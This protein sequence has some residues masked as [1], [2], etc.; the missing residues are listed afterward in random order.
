MH[1]F[2]HKKFKNN[3][4]EYIGTKDKLLVAI[5]SGQDSLCL[6]QLI[7]DCINKQSYN[8]QAIYIDHQWKKDSFHHTQHIVNIVKAK[9]IPIS[10]YE[11]KS[12]AI[13]ENIA[14]RIRYKTFIKHAIQEKC[15]VVMTGHHDNDQIETFLYNIIRGTS[16][17][18]ISNL[19]LFKKLNKKVAILRPLINFSKYE[20][21]WF[22]RLFHL[23]IWSD[24]TNYNFSMRRN[25][26]RHELIPYLQ[27][28]F[29]PQIKQSIAKFINL[30]AQENEYIKENTIKLYILITHKRIISLN[31]SKLKKQ[32]RVL[33]KRVIKLF[34]YYHFNKQIN[35][36]L[37][38]KILI[39]YKLQKTKTI[40][41]NGLNIFYLNGKIY[42]ISR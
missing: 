31:L 29:N 40:F 36:Y 38:N 11:I 24:M 1:T 18:G 17:S 28:Y 39:L 2:S 30:C 5:S 15:P 13:S 20:I 8:I 35:N 33:K 19:T 7:N 9:N 25:R 4:E 23:P 41:F 26:I 6:M 12:L 16:I 3:C 21:S 22:C 32:H 34:F 10:I 37:I 42:I 27:N 14:R